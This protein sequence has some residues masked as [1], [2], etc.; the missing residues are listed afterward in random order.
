MYCD[1]KYCLIVPTVCR[2]VSRVTRVELKT[3]AGIG[4]GTAPASSLV[5]GQGL[6]PVVLTS[7]IT[8]ELLPL[9]KP[10]ENRSFWGQPTFELG[11]VS[12]PYFV[13]SRTLSPPIPEPGTWLLF[14]FGVVCLGL[15]KY[16]KP[17]S[18]LGEHK[19]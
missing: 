14:V 18:D 8:V 4:P 19:E 13:S 15:L 2:N 10:A 6:V 17:P 1:G 16:R 11:A 7:E 3:M 12:G 5:Y 9:L